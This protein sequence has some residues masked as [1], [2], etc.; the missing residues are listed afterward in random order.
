M[1]DMIFNEYADHSDRALL[2]KI[3]ENQHIMIGKMTLEFHFLNSKIE[4]IMSAADD[5]QALVA[6]LKG[7]LDSIKTGVATIVAG[8]PAAGGLTADEV[9]A[10]K[11]SL[12]DAA[13]EASDDAAAVA[14]A[15][16]APPPA[17]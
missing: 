14:A 6:S 11:A 13:G 12:T 2:L 5:L 10:L 9:A 7:S 15:Q 3:I 16:P 4:K 17:S 8:L 1:N